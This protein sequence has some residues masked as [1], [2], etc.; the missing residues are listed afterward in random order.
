MLRLRDLLATVE[1]DEDCISQFEDD[2]DNEIFFEHDTDT[3]EDDE[4]DHSDSK[5]DDNSKDM[6]IQDDCNSIIAEN[7]VV[8][9]ADLLFLCGGFQ[10]LPA[11]CTRSVKNETD[12][13]LHNTIAMSANVHPHISLDVTLLL[14]AILCFAYSLIPVLLQFHLKILV[15]L[16]TLREY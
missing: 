4:L 12:L 16:L 9:E 7:N 3:E 10:P 8:F 11:S 5:D 14:R 6:G 13:K 1:S 15:K 2:T